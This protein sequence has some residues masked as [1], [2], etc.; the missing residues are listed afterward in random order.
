[1]SLVGSFKDGKALGALALCESIVDVVGGKKPMPEWWWSVL[2]QGKKSRQW[3]R[4]C[5][6]EPSGR[7]NQGGTSW[8]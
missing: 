7:G 4:A 8:F 1:M 2:Y 6:S 3:A 5:S